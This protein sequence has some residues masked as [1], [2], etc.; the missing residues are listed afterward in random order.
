MTQEMSNRH[1]TR[2]MPRRTLIKAAAGMVGTAAMMTPI[3]AHAQAPGQATPP[4]VVSN[5]PRQWGPD[6][7]PNIYPDP[8]V[9]AVDPSFEKY[10]VFNSPI[11]RL[12]T[13]A[14]WAEGPAWNSEGRYLLWSDVGGNVQYRWIQEDGRVTAYRTPSNNSNGNT[15]DFQGRQLSCQDFFRRV[16]RWE[17]DGSMTV[18]A[19]SYNGKRLNSP[20]DIVPHPD[21]SVWFTDPPY[22]ESL[23]EGQPDAGG[24]LNPKLGAPDGG[25]QTRQL[26]NSIYRVD[27]SGRV[28]LVTDQVEDPNGL[29]FS[30]DYKRLYVCNTGA[31]PGDTKGG[32]GN[33]LAFD[34]TGDNKLANGAVFS[35]MMIDG[36]HCGPDGIRVDVDGN[37]WCSSNTGSTLGYNGVVVFT[38][39][40]KLIGRIR[41]PEVCANLCFGGLKRNRLFMTAS[42]SIYAVY[43]N[44]QGAAPG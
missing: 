36:V 20:N 1:S 9:L 10:R 4:S 33:I 39:Q 37:L 30:Q 2:S 7:P 5:P 28:D 42:Q 14:L 23:F 18:L 38:P 34:V 31:G 43:V 12:W 22:G 8:D 16:V 29:C 13:G 32:P 40:A 35:D 25:G 24:P 26:P 27:P 41:L 19:D 15:F 11:Q 21:G 6:A 17:L 44:T 3:A